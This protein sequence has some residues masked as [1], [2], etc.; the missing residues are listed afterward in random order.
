MRSVLC[1]VSLAD[2]SG[3]ENCG[4][5][6]SFAKDVLKLVHGGVWGSGFGTEY[7]VLSTQC[8]HL[9]TQYTVLVA[10][11]SSSSNHEA[12]LSLFF[13]WYNLCRK[14]QTLKTTPA[15]AAGVAVETGAAVG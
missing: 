11:C 10:P 2:A 6:M 8:L 7:S 15:V 12:A 14:H 9:R 4:L 1:G 13:A 3:Y 5:A